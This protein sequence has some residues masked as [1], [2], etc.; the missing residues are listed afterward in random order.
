MEN[1][2]VQLKNMTYDELAGFF[3]S[4]GEKRFRASQVFK[5]MYQGASEFN[6]MTELPKGLRT[7]LGESAELC[8]VRPLRRQESSD[9]TVKYLFGV[10]GGSAIESVSM[11]YRYGNTAC[12]SSQAGCRMGCAFCASAAGGLERNLTAGEIADQVVSMQRDTGERIG[13]IVVMGTGEPF[14]NYDELLRAISIIH[15][16]RGLNIGLRNI[17][18]STCGLVDKIMRFA[19]DM[20]QVNLAV[21]LHAPSD[22]IRR[23]LMP[24]AGKYG[25][26]EQSWC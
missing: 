19:E 11:K 5:R 21:S 22:D 15:D 12:V 8:A 13:H 20:P 2:R 18:V 25:M 1:E 17:T 26:A 10:S 14:D 23:R 24:I 3:T 9:G 16:G 4:M 6:E 7:A